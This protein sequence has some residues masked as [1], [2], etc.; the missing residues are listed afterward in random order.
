LNILQACTVLYYRDQY[1]HTQ[2]VS[3]KCPATGEWLS[4]SSFWKHKRVVYRER[5]LR[6]TRCSTTLGPRSP[7]PLYQSLAK[8]DRTS[9]MMHIIIVDLA[10]SC[11][12]IPRPLSDV[13]VVP[14]KKSVESK[15]VHISADIKVK[16][17]GRLLSGELPD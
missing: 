4:D 9:K 15:R 5:A 2:H 7:A 8:T 12:C 1:Y 13:R 11:C 3:Q 16:P 14:R 17:R 6:P 10:F